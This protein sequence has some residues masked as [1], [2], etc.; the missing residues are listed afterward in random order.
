[1]FTENA[2]LLSGSAKVRFILF[3]FSK[4]VTEN[5]IFVMTKNDLH[6]FFEKRSISADK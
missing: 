1:M 2:A 3:V 6:F 4:S 5:I